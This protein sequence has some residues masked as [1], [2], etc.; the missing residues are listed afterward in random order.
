MTGWILALAARQA[1]PE[2]IHETELIFPVNEKHNHASS[3]VVCPDGDLLACWFHGTGERNSDDV[4]VQ[5][6]RK[7][8]GAD[9]WSEPFLMT[10]TP[11]LPDC[12]PVM[13]IDP[14]G[15]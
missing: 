14:Q 9:S 5:G 15:T 10:D 11:N 3:I 8:K 4:L 2:A 13:F 12:N 6:A 1:A 7:R